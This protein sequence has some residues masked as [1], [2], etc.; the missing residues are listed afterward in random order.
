MAEVLLTH[1]YH[2][3]YDSKQLRK[4]QPYPPLGTLYAATALRDSGISVAVFDPM[5]EEPSEPLAAMLIKHRPKIVAVYEDDF[6]FL[7]KMCLT[8]MRAVASQIAQAARAMGARVIV[9]GSDSTDNPSLFLE[10]GFDYVLRGESEGT[11]V[12]LCAS[13]LKGSPPP[14]IDGFV[15]RDDA[16]DL[17]Q[18]GQQLSKNPAWTELVL[19][20]RDLIDLEPYR[21]AWIKSHGYF[22]TN[23]V[24]SRGCPYRCNWCAKPISG[25]K[26]HLRPASAVAEEM[27]QLKK[28]TGVQHLW[29]GDD[30]F[31]LNQH[32]VEEFAAEVSKRDAAIPFKIQSRADLMNEQTVQHLKTAGCAEVWLGVESGS[33]AILNA[34]DKGLSLSMVIAV[35]HRLKEAGIRACFFLQLGYPGETWVE[36]QQT[37][38]LVRKLR[39]DDIGVSFS[40]PLPGTVFYERVQA[41]LGQKRNWADSDDLCIMFKAAYKTDFYRCVRDALHAEVDAWH[42]SETSREATSEV[43]AL[44]R[45]VEELEPISRCEDAFEFPDTVTPFAASGLVP[46]EDLILVQKA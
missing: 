29:F 41:Q 44:W 19:P 39:P 24:S 25:N 46:V 13:L 3:P 26:F 10:N 22:S 32:W 18:C 1:S 28:Q 38:A 16:G 14:E 6:N 12:L 37:I 31:A 4:M 7:S 45:K 36:L 27:L 8:R 23:I 33:Q 5:L 17:I 40:Y 11:L 43:E 21:E 35:R 15:R 9:H 2:L 34:M 30:V 20:A 42:V